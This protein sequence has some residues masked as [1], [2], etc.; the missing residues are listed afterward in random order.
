MKTV[1]DIYGSAAAMRL[2]TERKVLSRYTRLPGLPSSY[3]GLDTLM[4]TDMDFDFEDVL[5]GT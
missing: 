3:I 2:R 1:Q 5:N 4:G